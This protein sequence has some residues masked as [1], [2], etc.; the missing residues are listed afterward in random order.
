MLSSGFGWLYVLDLA[1]AN[2]PES[3]LS[4]LQMLY[5]AGIKS[6]DIILP[7]SF[8][9]SHPDLS[10]PLIFMALPAG[11]TLLGLLRDEI[12]NNTNKFKYLAILLSI[13]FLGTISHDEFY[14]F[15]IVASIVP[16]F[17]FFI[18]ET[19]DEKKK[20]FVVVYAALLSA[21]L[22]TVVLATYSFA[23]AGYFTWNTILG[24]PLLVLCLIFVTVM[25]ILSTAIR[26]FYNLLYQKKYNNVHPHFQSLQ[27]LRPWIM[28]LYDHKRITL[29]PRLLLVFVISWLYIATFIVWSQL[30]VEAVEVQTYAHTVPWYLYPMKLGVTGLL[31]FAF[32]L[33]YLFRKFEKEIFIFGI[34]A[35][36]A[37][38]AGPYYFEHRLD[39]Y[40]MA[41]L[42]GLASLS[43][44]N[45][46]IK[47][48]HI[49]RISLFRILS[50]SLVLGIV[51]FSS[52]LSVLMF[53]G[54]NT[55]A[56]DSDPDLGYPGRRD[57]P[58]ASEFGLYRLLANDSSK[59]PLAFSIAA[60]A[61][62]YDLLLPSPLFGKV[63]A[64]SGIPWTKLTQSPLTLDAY[65]LESFYA[66]LS[67]SDTRYIVLPKEILS[68]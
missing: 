7:T 20:N 40:I 22:L 32:I 14:L 11:F 42:A 50:T 26:F 51:I 24:I 59:D 18:A 19:R 15:I 47:Y 27:S 39:K 35:V 1:I 56:H 63:Y 52:A 29:A 12:I 6:I 25:C 3:Q 36:V 68:T 16:I 57:F 67:R 2:P 9:G 43:I 13:T 54:Y 49:Q 10:T 62:E 30:P 28:Y 21:L 8:S 33:S 37:F 48:T 31:G 41:S 17:L 38:V 64:F 44:Y 23:G 66:L 60:P 65:T 34:I 58:P 5:Q 46:I 4:T 45:M 55:S 61:K 53:W